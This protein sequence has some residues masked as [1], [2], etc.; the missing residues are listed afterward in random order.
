L[1]PPRGVVLKTERG[2]QIKR[3]ER[4][5]GSYTRERGSKRKDHSDPKGM[6]IMTNKLVE[7]T[8]KT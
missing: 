2:G 8:G 6:L 7:R 3:E 5:R 1:P 4:R